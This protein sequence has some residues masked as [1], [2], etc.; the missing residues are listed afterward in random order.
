MQKSRGAVQWTV[1]AIDW[2][3]V[4]LGEIAQR[5]LNVACLRKG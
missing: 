5:A 3:S 4:S 1:V 2:V